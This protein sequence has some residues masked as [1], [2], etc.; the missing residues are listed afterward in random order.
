MQ[1]RAK[2]GRSEAFASIQTNVM[3][4]LEM[5][6][7]NYSSLKECVGIAMDIENFRENKEATGRTAEQMVAEYL[8]GE[9][10]EDVA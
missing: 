8:R 3:G 4:N 9:D 7:P 6:I 1:L 2:N 10:D 5:L